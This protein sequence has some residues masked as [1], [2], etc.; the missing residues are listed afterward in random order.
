MNNNPEQQETNQDGAS[1]HPDD[2]QFTIKVNTRPKHL[3][4]DE[5]TFTEVVKLAFPD[6]VE[7]EITLYTVSFKHGPAQNSEGTMS[8]GDKVWIKSGMAFYVT[9]SDKS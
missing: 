1:A 9:P 4:T 8:M 3:Q 6:A 5:L 2:K 7:N